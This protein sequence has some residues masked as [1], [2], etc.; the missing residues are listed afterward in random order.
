MIDERSKPF[1]GSGLRVAKRSEVELASA[2]TVS[3][4]VYRSVGVLLRENI[5]WS[6]TLACV[7]LMD[8]MQRRGRTKDHQLR[9]E[10]IRASR[11]M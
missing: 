9:K 11:V 5:R 2:V 1:D 7:Q 10:R 3:P 8:D 4:R 6:G